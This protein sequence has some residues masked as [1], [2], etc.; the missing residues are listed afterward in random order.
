M[1]ATA[2]FASTDASDTPYRVERA[3]AYAKYLRLRRAPDK[4]VEFS[5]F[6]VWGLTQH[7][8]RDFN[9]MD[10][11]QWFYFQPLPDDAALKGFMTE[12]RSDRKDIRL[13]IHWY[14]QEYAP[15][16]TLAAPGVCSIGVGDTREQIG[17]VMILGRSVEVCP[18]TKCGLAVTY[19]LSLEVIYVARKARG[20]LLGWALAAYA[21]K[22]A[23]DDL[24]HLAKQ[25]RKGPYQAGL[26]SQLSG[27]HLSYG[28]ERIFDGLYFQ[29]DTVYG[30]RN[31]IARNLMFKGYTGCEMNYEN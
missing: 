13:L 29:L 27:L 20:K 12:H 30:D 31:Q 18:A 3:N 25:I 22:M 26:R 6:D 8:R 21:A 1:P 24:D 5:L 15:F 28:A 2:V 11:D 16:N 19:N 4:P 17:G 7:S 23:F 9:D 14:S 10:E